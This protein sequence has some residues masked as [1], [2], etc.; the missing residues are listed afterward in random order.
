MMPEEDVADTLEFLLLGLALAKVNNSITQEERERVVC[1]LA[2]LVQQA[3]YTCIIA[4][5]KPVQVKI[6]GCK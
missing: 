4:G 1:N 2:Q 5:D 3:G 6:G